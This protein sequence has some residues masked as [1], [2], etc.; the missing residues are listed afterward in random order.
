MGYNHGTV[1]QE[2]PN[3]N[4]RM[5][6]MEAAAA[7]NCG[8]LNTSELSIARLDISPARNMA[9]P[10]PMEPQYKVHLRPMRSSVKL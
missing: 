1:S 2:A 6:A 3:T 5:M 7:L 8:A 10:W 9:I 4:A